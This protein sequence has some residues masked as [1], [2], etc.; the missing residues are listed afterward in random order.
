MLLTS[1]VLRDRMAWFLA[2]PVTAGSLKMESTVKEGPRKACRLDGSGSSTL[3]GM[4]VDLCRA[5]SGAWG[6]GPYSLEGSR[7]SSESGSWMLVRRTEPSAVEMTLLARGRPEDE[8]RR[9]DTDTDS[10]L[11]CDDRPEPLVRLGRPGGALPLAERKM[12]RLFTR[13]R[14]TPDDCAERTSCTREHKHLQVCSS[15]PEQEHVSETSVTRP[16]HYHSHSV[17]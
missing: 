16:L 2:P 1:A 5:A 10:A 17:M 11:L 6:A 12:P 15:L 4:L 9:S 7:L 14:D 8:S 13:S 3:Q